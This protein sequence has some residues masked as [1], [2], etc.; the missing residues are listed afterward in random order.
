MLLSHLHIGWGA[1][2]RRNQQCQC[3]TIIKMTTPNSN[4]QKITTQPPY[5]QIKRKKMGCIVDRMDFAVVAESSAHWVGS[6]V[7]KK[8]AAPPSSRWQHPIPTTKKLQHSHHASTF[9]K[10]TQLN[11]RREKNKDNQN[12]STETKT[13]PIPIPAETP[14]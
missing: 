7:K 13:H 12:P 11:Q 10:K 1:T 4:H 3:A 6:Y 5:N 8:P 14:S 2:S 9:L